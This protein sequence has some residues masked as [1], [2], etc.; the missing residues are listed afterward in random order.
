M[1]AWT[2]GQ[3]RSARPSSVQCRNETGVG[4]LPFAPSLRLAWSSE[5]HEIP[6]EFRARI[7]TATRYLDGQADRHRVHSRAIFTSGHALPWKLPKSLGSSKVAGTEI[8]FHPDN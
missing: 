6:H 3:A 4:P 1:V 5:G 7:S 8:S 2:D